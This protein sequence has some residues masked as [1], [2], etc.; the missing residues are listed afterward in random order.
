MRSVLDN[1]NSHPI[2]NI[3]RFNDIDSDDSDDTIVMNTFVNPLF[4]GF[5]Q[6]NN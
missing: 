6:G 2:F 5:N 3:Q 4:R 1:I